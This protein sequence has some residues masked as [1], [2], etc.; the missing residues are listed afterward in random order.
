MAT[1]D[2]Y[3]GVDQQYR[4][5]PEVRNAINEAPELQAR[6][7]IFDPDKAI[8]SM[9]SWLRSQMEQ[10][11]IPEHPNAIVLDRK[12]P[13]DYT[14]PIKASWNI[15]EL[16]EYATSPGTPINVAD[17]ADISASYRGMVFGGL[18]GITNPQNY[19][20]V[21]VK[22]TDAPYETAAYA[23][24]NEAGQWGMDLSVVGTYMRGEWGFRLEKQSEPGVAVGGMWPADGPVYQVVD[25]ELRAISDDDSFVRSQPA[26]KSG[27]VT[28]LSSTPGEKRVVL[29]HR[30]TQEVLADSRIYTG[31][32]RS[33]IVKPGEAGYGTRFPEQSYSYDQAVALAAITAM[34]DHEMASDLMEG[35]FRLQT[36]GGI[37]DGGFRFSGRQW[38]ATYGDPAYRTGAHAYAVHAA[39]LYVQM[40]PGELPRYRSRIIRGLQ[41]LDNRLVTVGNRAGLYL[42]GAGIYVPDGG[43][44]QS[45]DELRKITWASTEHNIDAYFTYRLAAQVINSSYEARATALSS[46]M[47]QKLW[48]PS[49]MRL[50]QGVQETGPDIADA[51][52]CHSWG[53]IFLDAIGEHEKARIV[54]SEESLAP[55]RFSRT[56]PNGNKVTG[57]AGFY[58]SYGYE[59]AR[60]LVWWE[61][62][63]GVAEA[64]WK[65]RDFGRWQR[66]LAEMMPGQND[67]GSFP[68]VSNPDPLYEVF[69]YKAVAST[70]WGIIAWLGGGILDDG[71]VKSRHNDRSLY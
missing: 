57:Y 15:A 11:N 23:I 27:V 55:F 49:L 40:W 32:I 71:I 33:F 24:P 20:V 44:G 51:L 63:F 56:A 18:T 45:F 29:R 17:P 26:P 4:F 7:S 14:G 3:P 60:P 38:S 12:Y 52:D 69:T 39:L 1:Y 43:G 35:L 64:F 61:G 48:N 31:N 30:I 59:G 41:W 6:V 5:P 53:A 21:A 13:I 47:M 16:Q 70:A 65:L 42:G 46:V 34:G 36:N 25:V 28:F 67:D 50:N 62:S 2:I 10:I 9:R 58:D 54:M 37:Y 68:Y 8:N 19:K 66:T 22:M